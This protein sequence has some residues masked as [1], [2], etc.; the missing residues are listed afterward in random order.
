MTRIHF[1]RGFFT[2]GGG[3]TD[4]LKNPDRKRVQSSS[5]GNKYSAVLKKA[6]EEV[7]PPAER[8]Y[9]VPLFLLIYTSRRAAVRAEGAPRYMA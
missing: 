7:R 8:F 6:C 4:A 1:L 5:L 3:G 2:D 9:S